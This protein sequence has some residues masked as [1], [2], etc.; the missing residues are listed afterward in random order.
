[1][2]VMNE[3]HH[4]PNQETVLGDMIAHGVQVREA[5]GD[6]FLEARRAERLEDSLGTYPGSL[7]VGEEVAVEEVSP[8]FIAATKVE[9][10]E[11]DSDNRTVK[12]KIAETRAQLRSHESGAPGRIRNSASLIAHNRHRDQGYRPR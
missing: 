9:G 12:E 5:G 2:E 3:I 7:A 8:A 1:M 4:T 10:D 11:E 6:A